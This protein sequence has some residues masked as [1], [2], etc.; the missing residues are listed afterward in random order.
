MK[1]ILNRLWQ[2]AGLR[3]AAAI[4]VKSVV[5]SVHGE[6]NRVRYKDAELN[7]V[8][9]DIVGNGN[10]IIIKPGCVLNHVTFYVRG[11]NHRVIIRKNCRF[12]GGGCVWLEGDDCVLE[13][14]RQ[15]SFENV[16]LALTEEGSKMSIGRDCM[17]AYSFEVR[18]GDSHSV[19]S[20]ESNERINYAKDVHI[21][22]HV[23]VAAHCII[24]KGVSIASDSIVASGA[25]VT[26]SF[27][28]GG[29]VIGGNPAVKIKEGITWSR[30]RIARPAG[31]DGE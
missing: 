27:D 20:R 19:L 2:K 16:H 18:T 22:D 11:D 21:G 3:K 24:L 23:W 13:I 28:T 17:F 8:R 1:E 29:I 26:R 5:R 7:S 6:N 14:G 4:E 31:R 15:S 12:N 30:A 10:R 9:F 25:V